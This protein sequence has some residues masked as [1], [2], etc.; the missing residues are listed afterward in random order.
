MPITPFF[1]RLFAPRVMEGR[2]YHCDSLAEAQT[3]IDTY[4]LPNESVTVYTDITNGSAYHLGRMTYASKRH[5]E[6]GEAAVLGGGGGVKLRDKVFAVLVAHSGVVLSVRELA[7][8]PE[9]EGYSKDSVSREAKALFEEGF[10]VRRGKG[11]P[12]DPY[13]YV[14]GGE[15]AA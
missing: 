12:Q 1:V 13:L 14:V 6:V 3:V 4:R 8:S 15:V 10:L 11:T 9:L 5:F 2:T 7:S